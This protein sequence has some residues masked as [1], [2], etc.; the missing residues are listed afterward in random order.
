MR[1]HLTPRFCFL[2]TVPREVLVKLYFITRGFVTRFAHRLRQLEHAHP[3]PTSFVRFSV[4]FPKWSTSC[5]FFVS[6]IMKS[7]RIDIKEKHR[8]RIVEHL[9]QA[10]V[11][12]IQVSASTPYVVWAASFSPLPL[13]PLNPTFH[14]PISISILKVSPVWRGHL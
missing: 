2:A 4:T 10:S 9:P 5:V 11:R 3:D 12:G 6:R 13:S 8:L 7:K 14:Y 1:L